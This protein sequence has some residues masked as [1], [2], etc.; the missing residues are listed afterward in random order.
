MM[1][2]DYENDHRGITFIDLSINIYLH[3]DISDFHKDSV[4]PNFIHWLTV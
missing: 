2:A 4:N 3:V 1:A